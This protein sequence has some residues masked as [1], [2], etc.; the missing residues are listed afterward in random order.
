M[1]TGKSPSF[2]FDGCNYIRLERGSSTDNCSCTPIS[3]SFASGS[4]GVNN[5]ISLM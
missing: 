5:V 1:R 2:R 3:C 4:I